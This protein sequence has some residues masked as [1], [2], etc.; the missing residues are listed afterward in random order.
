MPRYGTEVN[1]APK[2]GA[3]MVELKEQGTGA[4]LLRAAAAVGF[5]FKE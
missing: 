1:P 4:A 3:D 2:P 5:F